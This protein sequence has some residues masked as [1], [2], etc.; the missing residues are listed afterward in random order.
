MYSY[1]REIIVSEIKILI[2]S[3]QE[4]A[5]TIKS[6]YSN[7][8]FEPYWQNN[9]SKINNLLNVLSDTYKE[10]IPTNRYEIQNIINLNSST[11]ESDIA[12]LDIM[13]TEK[14]LLHARDLSIGIVNPLQLSSFIE[15][16]RE[17]S[18]EIDFLSNLT[19]EINIKNYFESLRPKNLDYLKLMI[20]LEKLKALKTTNYD[21][22][23][24]PNDITLEVGM[25]HPNVIP[26]RN[27][28][29]ELN[30]LENSSKSETFDDDLLK[31]VL[32]FQENSGLVSDGVIGKKTY[33]ALN[34]STQTKLIQVMVN[35]ERLRWLNFDFGNQYILINQANYEAKYVNENNTIWKSKVVIG[36]PDYQTAEF[37]D[38]MTHIIVNPTW[39]VPKSIAVDEYLP[40]IQEDPE[41][42]VNNEMLLYV[43][44]TN[45]TI[46]PNLIDM[47]VFTV[48]NFP[49]EIK[50]NPG[51]LNAL[52]QVKFMFPNKHS[53]Y[54]HD[55]PMKS[56]FSKDLRAFSH[57]CVRLARPFEFAN[58]LLSGDETIDNS[59]FY[60]ALNS[61][62]ETR[63]NLN[64]HIP[65]YMS[66]RTVLFDEFGIINYRPDIYGR[67][68]LVYL[69][70]FSYG[71]DQ[72]V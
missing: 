31:S 45:K 5:D 66:Y 59:K 65:V 2:E 44:G 61:S 67:D 50:Q 60:S 12:K 17:D 6:F 55:T 58:A 25:S 3:N 56:L 63:F 26:L 53:I 69:S 46:D 20:E 19:K 7:N 16:K 68:A 70:L 8:L 21:Q 42:L 51:D 11:K 10:G 28:L 62:E 38:Q 24:V 32:L 72:V 48:D 54:M 34:L 18:I 35:L 29:I 47:S 33:Q 40:K 27:R 37:F 52:G 14:F 15:I 13:L 64:N 22:T 9:K 41:F 57:G 39:H 43:R 49:F 71:L 30:I 4:I 36:L 1:D 23:I